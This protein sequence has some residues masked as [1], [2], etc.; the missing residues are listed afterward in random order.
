VPAIPAEVLVVASTPFCE[1]QKVPCEQ[2]NWR[3]FDLLAARFRLQEGVTAIAGVFMKPMSG[4]HQVDAVSKQVAQIPH[5]FRE[6]GLRCKGIALLSE[7]QGMTTL[8][9]NI[10]VVARP[11]R[12]LLIVMSTEKTRH[13]M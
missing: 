6:R 5:F 9:T 4:C 7:Q 12:D 3:M 2:A 8:D 10:L 11:H 1:V 13:G